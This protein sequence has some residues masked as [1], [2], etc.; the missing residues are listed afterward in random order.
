M[1]LC[2][3]CGEEFEEKT[4]HQQYCNGKCRERAKNARRNQPGSSI[5]G[6]GVI[7]TLLDNPAP[8]NLKL[9]DLNRIGHVTPRIIN[10]LADIA[11]SP[12]V[13]PELQLAAVKVLVLLDRLNLDKEKFVATRPTEV[14]PLI[15][16][17]D[18]AAED[19]HFTQLFSRPSEIP[20]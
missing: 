14:A 19:A 7:A 15:T 1:K 18:I 8:N 9:W 5:P 3:Q 6:A 11:A 12:L 16:D 10:S 13:K 2:S 17:E 20:S 4:T